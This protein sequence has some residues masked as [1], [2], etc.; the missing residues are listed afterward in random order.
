MYL[1]KNTI[2]SMKKLNCLLLLP[3]LLLGAGL[4]AQIITYPQG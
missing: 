2:P 4:Y 3:A 1:C